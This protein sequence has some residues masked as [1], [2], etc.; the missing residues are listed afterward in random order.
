MR[1]PYG[2]RP[3][4][5]AALLFTAAVDARGRR[6][7]A[8]SARCR[9]ACARQSAR[10]L[11][12]RG[13]RRRARAI[14]D[15]VR[16]R[17]RPRTPTTSRAS[18]GLARVIVYDDA[19]RSSGYDTRDAATRP[20]AA[21]RLLACSTTR[22]HRADR[23][24]SDE[25]RGH[26]R[27]CTTARARFIGVA[28]A[29]QAATDVGETVDAGP[30]TRSSPRRSSA[31]SSRCCSALALSRTLTAP[32]RAA[33]RRGAPH[34]QRGDATRRRRATTRRDEV[35]DLARALASMQD[36]LSRQEQARR[37]FVATASHELRTPLTLA[38]A[39]TLELLD[40]DLARGAS[41]STTPARR[42]AARSASCA[43]SSTSRPTCSTSA[44]STP[45]SP[46]RSEP[47]ELGELSRAVG[48]GVRAAGRRPAASSVDVVPPIAPVLGA[49]RPG[50]GGAD[51]ADPARQ[52][53]ALRAAGEHGHASCPAYHGERATVEVA[54]R[55]PGR[56]GG[57]ARARSSSAS[58]AA[59]HTGGEEGFGLGLAIG[60]ELAERLGGRL[61]LV[62]DD[63][64][65]RDV[66]AQPADRAAGG[67]PPAAGDGE[68]S[69]RRLRP[70]PAARPRRP[71]SAGPSCRRARRRRRSLPRGTPTRR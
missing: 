68:L 15:D 51:R 16:A 24:R 54:R 18:D 47:V 30:R 38:A 13:A 8:A 28:G 7:R 65:R 69:L 39:A 63:R 19:G 4:L 2:L 50:R 43:G 6:A 10:Q 12:G 58:S 32:P 17:A 53:A 20:V 41:T 64:A 61:E 9:T 44:G 70:W 46:L 66:R 48:R 33:A 11:A 59:A 25:A 56:P 3:R 26:D 52:R 62:E 34:R 35:G 22:R 49:G 42:S 36:S 55:R 45:R 67:I 31:S 37:A 5:L 71:G 57:G 27:A 60:R 21:Q 23:S 14:E 29:A 40:E 1:R